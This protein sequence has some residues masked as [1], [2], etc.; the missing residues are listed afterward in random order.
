MVDGSET[1]TTTR[2]GA[3][4]TGALGLGGLTGA[5]ALGSGH[6]SAAEPPSMATVAALAG[7]TAGRYFL[8][9]DSIPGD[10]TDARHAGWIET[11]SYSWGASNSSTVSGSGWS[12]SKPSLSNLSFVSS[13]G[14]ASPLLF[15][16]AMNGKH[17]ST[18]LLEGMTAGTDPSKFVEI[19]LKDVA[20]ASYQSA[21]SDG[22]GLPT[23]SFSLAFASIR[24][25]IFLQSDN[26][27]PG[28]TISATWNVRTAS[29]TSTVT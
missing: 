1:P 8:Q 7:I 16:R 18:A 9:L 3:L 13:F 26:G 29:G 21:A 4:K 12:S 19:E 17:L 15:L 27:G 6:A 14:S 20:V 24:Y 23:D 11:L 28:Q 10:S 25:T 5:M 22:G 2:R